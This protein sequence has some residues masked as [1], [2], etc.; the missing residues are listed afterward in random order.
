VRHGYYLDDILVLPQDLQDFAW[1]APMRDLAA[2]VGISD[3]GLKKLLKSHGVITPPQGFWNRVHARKPVPKC[4]MAPT[5]RPGESGRV[6]LDSRFASV[7]TAVEPLPSSGPFRS[8]GIPEDLNELYAQELKAIGR[9]T[10]PRTLGRFHCGLAQIFRQEERRRVKFAASNWRWD[11]PR[12]ESAVDRRRLRILNAIFTVLSRRGHS[13]DAYERD[14]QIH[15]GA[16]I[17][18]NHLGLHIEVAGRNGGAQVKEST[19]DLPVST[20]LV[21][22]VDPGF[23][24]KNCTSWQDDPTGKLETKIT[25]IAAAIVVAGE[26]KFRRGLKEA[27]EREAQFR[28]WEEQRRQEDIARRNRERLKHL[29]ESGQRLREAQ[30]LR[31]LILRVRE[32]VKVGSVDVDSSRLEEWEGWASA[33]ADRLD[34][35]TSGQVMTHLEPTEE[36]S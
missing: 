26:A 4:P 25:E 6:H 21:F 30:D 16:T 20:A 14:G 9:A 33:E 5:R 22:T 11:A 12:F 17:G 2:K 36:G 3:V 13:A 35:I 29:R 34:P 8:A 15:A 24:R 1:S 18:D 31:E 28:R 7:L 19:S 32:A 27:E 10:V 23:D